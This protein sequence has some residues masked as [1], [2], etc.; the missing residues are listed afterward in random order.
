[1]RHT[2]LAREGYGERVLVLPARCADPS[3]QN[4]EAGQGLSTRDGPELRTGTLSGAFH[5]GAVLHYGL[6]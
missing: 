4:A 1:M 5:R 3:R 6:F 2:I